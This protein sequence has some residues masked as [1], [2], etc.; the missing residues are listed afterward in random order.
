MST[1]LSTETIFEGAALQDRQ[2]SDSD[3]TVGTLQAQQGT[4]TNEQRWQF[5]SSGY[6]YRGQR[7]KLAY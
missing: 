4:P 6:R 7:D 3:N 2:C 5:G 1:W